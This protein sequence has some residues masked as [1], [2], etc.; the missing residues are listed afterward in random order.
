MHSIATIKSRFPESEW[1]HVFMDGCISRD[2]GAG[3]GVFGNLFNICLL[4]DSFSTA[5]DDKFEAI[6]V[7]I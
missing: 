6:P 2:H 3:A 5:V 4:V 7:A 1:L